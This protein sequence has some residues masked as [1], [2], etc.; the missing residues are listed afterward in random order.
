M[1]TQDRD[2]LPNFGFT[3]NE[4]TEKGTYFGICAAAT[5]FFSGRIA[6]ATGGN[7]PDVFDELVANAIPNSRFVTAGV[8]ALTRAQEYGYSLLYAG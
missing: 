2:D 7:Q 3:I 8:M 5:R 6:E 1:L 4:I